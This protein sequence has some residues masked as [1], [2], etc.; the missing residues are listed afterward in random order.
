MHLFCLL[1]PIR[2]QITA[3]LMLVKD[4]GQGSAILLIRDVLDRNSSAILLN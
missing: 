4:V 2:I 3:V 1:I